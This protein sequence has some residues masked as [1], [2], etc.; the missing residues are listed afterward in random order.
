MYKYT[1]SKLVIYLYMPHILTPTTHS[2]S[3][4]F[5]LTLRILIKIYLPEEELTIKSVVLQ[6]LLKCQC[7]ITY[8]S[9]NFCLTVL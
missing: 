8:F 2:V 9:S 7:H 6:S 4:F 5:T 1:Y 3:L